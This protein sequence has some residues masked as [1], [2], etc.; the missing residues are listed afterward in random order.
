MEIVQRKAA[1]LRFGRDAAQLTWAGIPVAGVSGGKHSLVGLLRAVR[2]ALTALFQTGLSALFFHSC[3][4]VRRGYACRRT[5]AAPQFVQPQACGG[6]RQQRAAGQQGFP[7]L[8]AGGA[9]ALVAFVGLGQYGQQGQAVG[10]GK[11]HP[12]LSSCCGGRRQ[13]S[14]RARARRAWQPRKYFSMRRA[15]FSRS[16][17]LARA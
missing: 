12:G 7:F 17:W 1:S 6:G 2:I 10:A 9:F 11:I 14:N 8:L 13:S 16:A 4:A 15:H 5:K 3:R